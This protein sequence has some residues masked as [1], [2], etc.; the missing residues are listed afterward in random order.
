MANKPTPA[1]FSPNVPDFPSIGQYQPIYG[2]FDL[3][4]YIQGAS[5]YEI[6]SFLVQ[7][8]NATLK[9]YSDV[10][11]LSKDTVTAYNQLQ[12]WV[13]TWF[14]NLD[15]KREVNEKL[16]QMLVS[17]ELDSVIANSESMIPAINNYFATQAGNTTLY[18]QTS[19]KIDEMASDGTLIDVVKGTGQI[20]PAVAAYLNSTEGTQNLS[21]ATAHKIEQ[22]AADG[23][24]TNMVKETGQI[25][26]ATVV[27]LNS[28]EGTKNLSDITSIKIN[29][30]A[31]DG[32]LTNVVKETGQISKATAVYLNSTE[33]T[34]N[35]SDATAHKIEQMSNNGELAAVISQTTDVQKTTTD[36]LTNNVT[37]VGSAVVVDNSLT[38]EGAA[39]DA[40]KTGSEVNRLNGDIVTAI[41]NNYMLS[42]VAYFKDKYITST[43]GQFKDYT[44][45]D[46][47]G[48]IRVPF[49]TAILSFSNLPERETEYNAFYD[50]NFKVIST[51]TASSFVIVPEN[52]CYVRCSFVAEAFKN[53]TFRVFSYSE[54]I[55]T[56]LNTLRF[57]GSFYIGG[58]NADNSVDV[59]AYAND[60]NNLGYFNEPNKTNEK[61]FT[62]SEAGTLISGN[63]YKINVP[64]YAALVLDVRKLV[65]SFTAQVEVKSYT[66][67]TYY[68]IILL[69]NNAKYFDELSGI[70][71]TKY[72]VGKRT[73]DDNVMRA[74]CRFGEGYGQPESVSAMLTAKKRGFNYIRVN[75]QTTSDN[76]LVLWHDTILNQ[77]YKNVYYG[78]TLVPYSDTSN[79]S[80]PNT[81][82]AMLNTYKYGSKSYT[83]GIPTLEAML[84]ACRSVGMKVYMECKTSL[85]QTQLNKLYSTINKYG[86]A[87]NTSVSFSDHANAKA[88]AVIDSKLRIGLQ[89]S[90]FSDK[91][92]T[93]FTELSA[94]CSN[95]Y[96]WSWSNM[97]L[98]ANIVNFLASKHIEFDCGD[99]T[100]YDAVD[101][102]LASDYGWYCTGV[103]LKGT[104]SPLIGQYL[105][106]QYHS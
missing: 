49:K 40:N 73:N 5:D 44:G 99:F 78:E 25:S 9:G 102:Y 76:V 97:P 7:C 92:R 54:V 68:D 80:I 65:R 39:A 59:I 56:V 18:N 36:W 90:T 43:H 79:T 72:V 35:L 15:V 89:D 95:L 77:N 10:T 61:Y 6:M 69:G 41:L 17:G 27:Y 103:E 104:V 29:E 32:T 86:M 100:T 19:G 60:R 62:C 37:P 20:N 45:W 71:P 64:R 3:T 8:Y 16:E 84:K 81:T 47:T 14:D 2:K 4:T 88:M 63:K 70:I 82:F 11:Q 34:K 22:M 91:V 105:A 55:T 52:T 74:I 46:A 83:A 51:F 13:N 96:W 42:K 58:F 98:T 12:T 48:Y 30:M 87:S 66:G 67:I 1:D 57:Q 50:S 23:T 38:I 85:T 33:G 75:L 93:T 106:D 21:D 24:L 101:A 26:Q 31:A 94:T 28:T 53:V